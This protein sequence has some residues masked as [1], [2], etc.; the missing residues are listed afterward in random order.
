MQVLNVKE[1]KYKFEKNDVLVKKNGWASLNHYYVQATSGE[2]LTCLQVD[3]N[4]FYS[5]FHFDNL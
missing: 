2:Y 4:S 3:S 1:N 5:D